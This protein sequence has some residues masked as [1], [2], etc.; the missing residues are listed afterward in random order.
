MP[1]QRFTK[2][3]NTPRLRRQWDKVY[4]SCLSRGA[5]HGAA[6]RQAN[7]VIAK[8]RRKAPR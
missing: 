3:A 1:A 5:T 8:A 6:V 4:R 7:G 2:K